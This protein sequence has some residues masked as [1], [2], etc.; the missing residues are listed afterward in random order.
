MMRSCIGISFWMSSIEDD[1]FVLLQ[2]GVG[3]IMQACM[4]QFA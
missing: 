1:C 4:R 3:I 2:L